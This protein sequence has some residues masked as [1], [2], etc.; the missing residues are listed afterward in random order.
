M[1]MVKN[2]LA[3]IWPGMSRDV[4]ANGVVLI[5]IPVSDIQRVV[6]AKP[7]NVYGTATEEAV[8][9]WQLEHNLLP[10]GWAG[11]NTILAMGNLL[12][13]GR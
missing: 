9:K 8:K 6:G 2:L 7:D 12:N 5:S 1:P 3:A 11:R 10:D 13:E 4:A